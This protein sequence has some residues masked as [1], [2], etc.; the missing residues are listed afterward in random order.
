MSEIM[1]TLQGMTPGQRHELFSH[2]QERWCLSC[3]KEL[4]QGEDYDYCP[5]CEA[6]D[7][8]S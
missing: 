7:G 5:D 2:M 4:V 1:R 3:G 6:E 8:E